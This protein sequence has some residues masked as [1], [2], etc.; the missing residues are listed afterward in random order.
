MMYSL[1]ELQVR[2]FLEGAMALRVQYLDYKV[3]YS[4]KFDVV[5]YF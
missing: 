3:L 2:R 4:T 5:P 1:V